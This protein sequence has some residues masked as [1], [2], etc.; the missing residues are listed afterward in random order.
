M[1]YAAKGIM[2]Y[3]KMVSEFGQKMKVKQGWAYGCVEDFILQNGKSFEQSILGGSEVEAGEKK[4]CFRNSFYL[5][6]ENP[7]FHYCEGYA[8]AWN[9]PLP[10]MHAWVVTDCGNVIDPTW[11]HG[12]AYFGVEI[13]VWYCNRVMVKTEQWGVLDSWKIRWPLLS[14][15]HS[16]PLAASPEN[17]NWKF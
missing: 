9:V 10:L 17:L 12:V 5:A 13:P 3:L 8:V 16:W 14:G 4:M 15:Q 7:L 2:D 6:L 1:N 11:K